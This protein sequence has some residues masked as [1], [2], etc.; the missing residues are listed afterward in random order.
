MSTLQQLI[1]T[2]G[3]TTFTVEPDLFDSLLGLGEKPCVLRLVSIL[4]NG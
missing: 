4:C 1:S 3:F 2:M